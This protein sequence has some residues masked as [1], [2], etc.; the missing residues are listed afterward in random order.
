MLISVLRAKLHRV[1]V[2]T[3]EPD[4]EG[5]LSVD[6]VLLERAGLLPNERV[7]VANV[8][9][10]E[11][12][13]TYLIPAPTGSGEVCVN[14]AA[15]RLAQPGDLIIV[16]AFAQMSSDEARDFRPTVVSVDEHNRPLDATEDGT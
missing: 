12:F 10:G 11:R 13:E 3:T 5:S 8:A 4:Y 16:M 6:E 14:G 7:L 15:A 9:N 2:T 1:R